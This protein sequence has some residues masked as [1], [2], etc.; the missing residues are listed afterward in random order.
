[1]LSIS[2]AAAL[3]LASG[4]AFA[5]SAATIFVLGDARGGSLPFFLAWLGVHALYGIV[6]GSFSSLVIVLACPPLLIA[7]FGPDGDETALWL[8][9]VFIEAFYGVPFAFMGIVARRLWQMRRRPESE[10]WLD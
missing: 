4:A 6:N 1:M 9:A 7:A 3:G 10:D 5:A 8:E 2:R